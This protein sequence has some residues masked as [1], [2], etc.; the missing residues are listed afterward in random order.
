MQDLNNTIQLLIYSVSSCGVSLRFSMYRWAPLLVIQNLPSL[1]RVFLVMR[2]TLCRI[3]IAILPSTKW[4]F[5]WS[6]IS[7]RCKSRDTG[8]MLLLRVDCT[9]QCLHVIYEQIE[10]IC[11]KCL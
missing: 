2:L 4:T 5:C 11:F 10:F 7:F 1:L 9:M 8:N 6:A 3:Q